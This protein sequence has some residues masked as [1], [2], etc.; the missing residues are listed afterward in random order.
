MES[1]LDGLRTDVAPEIDLREQGIVP[2]ESLTG[3]LARLLGRLERVIDELRPD[4]V[5]VQGDTNTTLAGALVGFH[6]GLPVFHVEAGLRTRDPLEPFPEEMNR[7]LVSR[8]A[9]LH[10]APTNSARDNLLAEAIAADTI[11]V[12]GNTGMDALRLYAESEDAR[13][14]AILGACSPGSRRLLV[15]LHRRENIELAG[16]AAEALARVAR[17]RPDVEVLWILHANETKARVT[18]ALAGCPSVQLLP[19]Q[20]YPTFV[21]L[22]A[23]AAVVLTDSGGVQ[24]EAPALGCPVLV[25]R[26]ATERPEAVEAGS[27]RIVGCRPDAISAECGRVLD[28]EALNHSMARPRALFGDGHAAER[29]AATLVQFFTDRERTGDSQAKRN[30]RHPLETARSR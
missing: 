2:G 20:P 10:F 21:R 19:P 3:A 23:A 30:N 8:L 27:A 6:H 14:Q 13:A 24:E 18:A 5:V 28:D 26:D 7:R 12:T 29:I 11:V 1:V 17:E 16:P 4:G 9:T 25:L 15:T 22:L